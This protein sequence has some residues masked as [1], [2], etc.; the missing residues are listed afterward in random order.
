MVAAEERKIEARKS[1]AEHEKSANKPK[2]TPRAT[3]GKP[4]EQDVD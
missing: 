3:K 4:A 2:S 1:A